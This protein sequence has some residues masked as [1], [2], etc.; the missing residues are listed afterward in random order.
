MT[1]NSISEHQQ[2]PPHHFIARVDDHYAGSR[3][4]RIAAKLFDEF[5]RSRLQQWIKTGELSVDSQRRSADYR[6]KGGEELVIYAAQTREG[7]WLAQDIALD[8]VYQDTHIIVLNKPIGLVVHPAVGNWVGTLL[9]GLLY[10]FPELREVPRAGVVHRLDKDTSGLMVVAKTLQAHAALV[11]QLQA[12]SVKR[13]Y[14]A[15]VCGRVVSSGVIDRPIAR[16]PKVRTKMA[17][18]EGG[19]QAIT[20]YAVVARYAHHSHLRVQLETGRTHQIRV[21]MAHI[22]HPL[23]GDSVYGGRTVSRACGSYPSHRQVQQFPRQALHAVALGLDHPH[24]GEE[25][26][27][28]AALPVDMADLLQ[29]LSAGSAT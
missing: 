16:H 23:V 25:L 13:E 24:T 26:R 29:L 2:D 22:Q 28:S 15:L 20:H 21:H 12:R 4:D 17:V 8:I 3:L 18:V 6:L 27:W 1:L 9:N 19:K 5:S 10:Q 11:K 7:E 14:E